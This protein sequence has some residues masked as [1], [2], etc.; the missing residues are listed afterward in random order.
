[1][2]YVQIVL[3]IQELKIKEVHVEQMNVAREKSF[4]LMAH[5]KNA[6]TTP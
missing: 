4:L 5:V 1:M 2:A 3:L 6:K